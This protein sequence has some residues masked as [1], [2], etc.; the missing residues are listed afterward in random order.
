MRPTGV[1]TGA[2]TDADGWM[3]DAANFWETQIN[4]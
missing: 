4:G 3:L 2:G 1:G